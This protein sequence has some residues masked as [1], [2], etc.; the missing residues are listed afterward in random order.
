MLASMLDDIAG[1]VT[2]DQE[3]FRTNAETVLSTFG[4]RKNREENRMALR[5]RTSVRIAPEAK[6]S[7]TRENSIYAVLIASVGRTRFCTPL[8]SLLARGDEE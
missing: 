8:K 3:N 5:S 6:N 4:I 2:A 7:S 1:C